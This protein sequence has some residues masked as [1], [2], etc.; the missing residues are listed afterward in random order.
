MP[1]Q[2]TEEKKTDSVAGMSIER[3]GNASTV[4]AI[5]HPEIRAGVCTFCGVKPDFEGYDGGGNPRKAVPKCK[6]YYG[7]KLFCTYCQNDEALRS[8]TMRVYELKSD[9]G[10]LIICC[11]DFRC[12]DKHQKKFHAHDAIK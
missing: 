2:T 8:R 1:T 12:E 9:P 7:V 6:H 4:D 3:H 11:D 10:K 5:V